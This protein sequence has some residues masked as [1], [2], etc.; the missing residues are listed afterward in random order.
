M[1]SVVVDH[2]RGAEA[3]H[4]VPIAGRRGGAHVGARQSRKLH[5]DAAH[6]TC[7]GMNQNCLTGLQRA[8]LVQ[9]LPG[10]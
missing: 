4:L 5:S 2:V 3:L 6:T 1:F 9:R 10:R 7:C 8:I